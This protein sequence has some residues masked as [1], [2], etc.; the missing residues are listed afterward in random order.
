MGK[1]PRRSRPLPDG[2]DATVPELSFFTLLWSDYRSHIGGDRESARRSLCL[3]PLRFLFNPSLQFSFLV[4]LAQCGPQLLH[5]PI[6]WLQVVLFSSEIYWF[7]GEEERIRIGPGANFPHP[8]GIIIGPGTVIGADVTIYNNVSIGTDRAGRA[9]DCWPRAATIGDRAIVY[10]YTTVM[11]PYTVWQ[12]G[13]VGMYT[14]L[15]EDVPAGAMKTRNRLRLAEEWD[16]DSLTKS[17]APAG[18]PS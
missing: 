13:V 1:A 8:I 17:V 7:R 6:R 2:L 10:G 9:E 4:R 14:V 11:G 16:R 3:A 18:R 15:D 12:D 5:H